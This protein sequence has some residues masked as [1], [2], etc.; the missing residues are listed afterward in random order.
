MAQDVLAD[1]LARAMAG[2]EILVVEDNA[3]Q[4]KLVSFLLEEA[5]HTVQIAGSAEIAL[6]VLE[7]FDPELILMD[8]QLPGKDGLQLTRELRLDPDFGA[9]P[10]I[11]LTAYTDKS[12]LARAREAGFN[13]TISK[14]IDTAAFAR[15]VR[16]YLGAMDDKDGDVPSDS[17]D[18]LT[19][20][21]N[22]FLAEGLEQC[23]R[24]LKELKS[25]ADSGKE[26]L[27]RVL[28]RWAGM[29]ETLGF[30]EIS[31]QAR[32]VQAL[33]TATRLE[34]D[35]VIRAIEA[36]QR[37]FCAATRNEPELPLELIRGLMDV[38]IGL[39]NF[40]EEE[41]NR[42][43]SGARR[44]NVHAVIERTNGESVENQAGYAALIINVCVPSAEAAV[45]RPQWSVP[46]VF[47]A[48]RA[49]LE[50]LAE[51]PSRAYDFL[52]APWEAEEVL[53]RVY[54]LIGKKTVPPPTVD[55]VPTQKRR[56]RILIADDDPDLVVLVSEI[57]GRFGMDTD[58]ARSGQQALD[59]VS[60]RPPDALILDVNMLDLDGF[61]VL[62]KLRRNLSTKELP[63]LLLTARSQA[64]DI[65][66]GLGSGADDYMVKPFDPSNLATR[67]E[68][69]I[70]ASRKRASIGAL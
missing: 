48:S 61:E 62:K 45:H 20:M 1:M 53:M 12:D 68:K 64:S 9:T 39:V 28:S 51:L 44:A 38:R 49:S 27:R 3:M 55:S 37:R 56:S 25:N 66:R 19:E 54:R 21:R 41:A 6:E 18:L 24:V 40:S 35:E 26:V 70:S 29:G 32:K 13:G 16:S 52:I 23:D 65:A 63:V 7:T 8:I 17:G 60:R 36:A 2:I 14:P 43:R 42:I 57:L 69:I 22:N 59:M 10:I 50:A 33:F 11:A 30:P 4:S 47:I 46:A 31:T 67:V 34:N 5:G 15:H 58:V